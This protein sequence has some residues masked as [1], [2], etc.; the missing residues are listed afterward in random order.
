[1]TKANPLK[2]N[3]TGVHN[4]KAVGEKRKLQLQ[5]LKEMRL[6]TLSPLSFTRKG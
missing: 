1:V 3:L 2:K 4:D 5:E 6:N